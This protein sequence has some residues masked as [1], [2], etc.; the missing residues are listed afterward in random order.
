MVTAEGP[1]PSGTLRVM[2]DGRGLRDGSIW[3]R[4]ENAIAR[5]AEAGQNKASIVEFPVTRG[6]VDWYTGR[7]LLQVADSFRRRNDGEHP[8]IR[9]APLLESRN[10][11]RGGSQKSL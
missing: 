10:G 4:S 11:S 2:S 9:D 1:G 3:L 5:I 8:D 7:C 6:A